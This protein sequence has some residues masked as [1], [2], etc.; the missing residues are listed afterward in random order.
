VRDIIV[1][2][3]NSYGHSRISYDWW[4]RSALPENDQKAYIRPTK[5]S[6]IDPAS[7]YIAASSVLVATS[8]QSA[9][10]RASALVV[11]RGDVTTSHL[12]AHNV[13]DG[14]L[15]SLEKNE[16]P[17]DF[18]DDIT[19]AT[20]P[21]ARLHHESPASSHAR[22]DLNGAVIGTRR[23]RA[24]S[25]P[26]HAHPER[27]VNFRFPPGSWV[28]GSPEKSKRSLDGDEDHAS[29]DRYSGALRRVKIST[30][31]KV[32]EGGAQT[33]C[34]PGPAFSEP[35]RFGTTL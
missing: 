16:W 21:C 29:I 12:R 3:A 31:Q 33:D 23:R 4:R 22:H 19:V 9:K 35:G 17:A 24:A 11:A 10:M 27:M 2:V 32:A 14:S 26:R 8:S 30:C 7:A 5:G 15:L 20:P 25:S 18:G 34:C 28:M 13:Q 6:G 1:P